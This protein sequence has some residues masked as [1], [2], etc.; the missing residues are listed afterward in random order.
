[1]YDYESQ[2]KVRGF[3]FCPTTAWKDCSTYLIWTFSLLLSLT[4]RCF[5]FSVCQSRALL[6]MDT[7]SCH[8]RIA[9]VKMIDPSSGRGRLKFT[10]LELNLCWVFFP[11]RDI[12]PMMIRLE[13]HWRTSKSPV[14]TLGRA[15][16][17]NHRFCW[18]SA[19]YGFVWVFVCVWWWENEAERERDILI[20]AE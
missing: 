10:A 11:S 19:S 2:S 4:L 6:M 20:I 15:V 17:L 14:G 8:L 5:R 12:L 3:D 18:R 1:M 16:V 13:S 7:Q 9:S